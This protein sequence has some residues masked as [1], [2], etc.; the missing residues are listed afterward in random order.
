MSTIMGQRPAQQ[1]LHPL[2]EI[3]NT[4]RRVDQYSIDNLTERYEIQIAILQLAHQIFLRNEYLFDKYSNEK[5]IK[6]YY[7]GSMSAIE[8]VMKEGAALIRDIHYGD[9]LNDRYIDVLREFKEFLDKNNVYYSSF[10]DDIL[11]L[12]FQQ[13]LPNFDK[14]PVTPRVIDKKWKIGKYIMKIVELILQKFLANL[15]GNQLISKTIKE[16]ILLTQLSMHLNNSKLTDFILQ[17]LEV[18]IHPDFK[19]NKTSVTSSPLGIENKY[20]MMNV[21]NQTDSSSKQNIRLRQMIS[22][23]NSFFII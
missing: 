10:L 13:I 7:S 12:I 1:T 6:T 21:L 8:G 3:F 14:M 11:M 19:N 9:I 20:W 15:E 22:S 2:L 17:T 16:N 5:Y 4:L 18:M 23:V